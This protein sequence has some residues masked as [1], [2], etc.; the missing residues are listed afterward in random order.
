MTWVVIALLIFISALYVAAEFAAVS[1]R[2]SRVR[3]KAEDGDRLARALLPYLDSPARLDRYIAAC[4]IGI[5]VSSLVLGAYGQARLVP[6]LEPLLARF[7]GMQEV[8]AESTAA[9]IIL[10][11][12]TIA[13]MV[14]GELVPKSLALQFPTQ[15]ALYT[16]VPMKWSLRAMSW[17]ILMLNGSGVLI[18]RAFGM[19]Q[20]GHRHLHSPEELEYLIA[21]SREGGLLQPNEHERLR[22][23]LQL[24]IRA[25]EDIMIPRVHIAAVEVNTRF[26]ELV[27]IAAESPYSRLPVYRRT[28]DRMTGF[29]HI[30]DVARHSINDDPVRVDA[31]LRPLLFIPEGMTADRVLQRLRD[32]RQHIAIV[33]DEFGGT[34]GLVTIGDVLDE[35]FG[36]IAEEFTNEEYPEPELLNDGR[37]RLAGLTRLDEAGLLL[38]AR[39]EGDSHTLGGLIA[40]HLGRIPRHGERF[41]IA[42]IEFEIDTVKSHVVQSVFARPNPMGGDVD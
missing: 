25:V 9:I 32:G 15:L 17:F 40:E 2:R 41:T 24:G 12:L 28:L 3:Q 8:A 35:I 1:V 7:S 4:Q 13:L 37:V 5:T 10:I 38:G 18:L 6:V 29:I 33:V 14:L 11:V 31:V 23:A 39:L 42:G 30:Q 20:T 36:G 21:E 22:R 26:D 16:V 34:K 19:R 27:T